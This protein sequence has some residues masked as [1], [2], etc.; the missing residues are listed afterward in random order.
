M[1]ITMLQKFIYLICLC[2]C[3]QNLAISPL[4][5]NASPYDELAFKW[6]GI[7]AQTAQMVGERHF[8]LPEKIEDC[9][10]EAIN[11]YLSCFD[12][13]SNFLSPK[14]YQEITRS[15]SG[16]FG[17]IG[18]IID[19]TRQTKDSF[20]TVIDVIPG[21]PADKQDVRPLDKIVEVDGSQLAGMTTEEVIAKLKGKI[22][23]TVDIKLLREKHPDMITVTVTRE[24]IQEQNSLC[25]YLPEQ[26]I[27]YLSLNSFTQNAIKQIEDLLKKSHNHP[28]KGLIIDMRFNT[29]GLLNAAIDII[30][31][32]LPNGSLVVQTK[33]RD[34]NNIQNYLTTRDPIVNSSLPIFILINNYTASAA[35][36]LAGCLQQ[37]SIAFAKQHNKQQLMVFLVGTRTFGKGS[38]QEVVPIGNDCAVKMTTALY[39]LPGDISIQGVGIEP[40]FE[41]NRMVQQNEQIQWFAKSHGFEKALPHTIQT[42]QSKKHADQ[43]KEKDK[44][45]NAESKHK[46]WSLRLQEGLQQDNQFKAAI[47][48]I[49]I[50]DLIKKCSGQEVLN[51]ITILQQLKQAFLDDTSLHMQEVKGT[52]NY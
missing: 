16:S 27:Y 26:K 47:N 24:I 12:P 30:G 41:I 32:F 52:L 2:V 23:T 5:T 8:Q 14:S 38:V 48:L 51:R 13:H 40:D 25:F 50:Y 46:K 17:G 21:G 22:D 44:K 31:L 49:N 4:V 7:L 20:L 28:Y 36:I 37:H 45:Q 35:E 11:A 6:S 39:F 42:S 43:Q 15:T 10:S 34:N 19:N 33:G 9:W 3:A 1:R 18:V 29:G